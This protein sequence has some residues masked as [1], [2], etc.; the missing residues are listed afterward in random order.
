MTRPTREEACRA[1]IMQ[2]V[3]EIEAEGLILHAQTLALREIAESA[4][5]NNAE[6]SAML[7][8]AEAI[9][10]QRQVQVLTLAHL[11]RLVGDLDTTKAPQKNAAPGPQRPAEAQAPAQPTDPSSNALRAFLS[12]IKA[13]LT[14]Q[15]DLKDAHGRPLSVLASALQQAPD[16]TTRADLLV[17]AGLAQLA[18]ML[19][20]E[21]VNGYAGILLD[22]MP[23]WSEVRSSLTEIAASCEGIGDLSAAA[24]LR[25]MLADGGILVSDNVTPAGARAVIGIMQ[26]IAY[27]AGRV[28][29]LAQA[30]LRVLTIRIT[31]AETLATPV[32]A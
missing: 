22:L 27:P 3:G 14:R 8:E 26:G 24:A 16:D 1:R 10:R 4:P 23:G 32:P 31:V 25:S 30:I 19:T 15:P 6:A 7:D 21:V 2:A 17:S 29:Q 20:R 9:D 18:G 12:T 13:A 5:P 11:Q 28:Q